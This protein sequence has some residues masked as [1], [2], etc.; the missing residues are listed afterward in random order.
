MYRT[1]KSGMRIFVSVIVAVLAAAL[2]GGAI[3]GIVKLVNY[4]NSETITPSL[5]W[6][7]GALDENGDYRADKGSLYTKNA[8]ECQ[9]LNTELCFDNNISYEV[10]FYDSTDEF[11]YSSGKQ[12]KNYA[13]TASDNDLRT[14]AVSRARIVITP[15]DDE[16]ITWFEKNGYAKQLEVTV[17][18]S[19][20][21]NQN[22]VRVDLEVAHWAKMDD[23]YIDFD[24]SE[25]F[26]LKNAEDVIPG[27]KT[28]S[29]VIEAKNISK[30]TIHV[31]NVN[32]RKVS[33]YFANLEHENYGMDSWSDV[34][35]I[36]KT[37]EVTKGYEDYLMVTVATEVVPSLEIYFM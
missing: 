25:G 1:K 21:A 30:V 22:I 34:G 7:V 26:Q 20:K 8:F 31:N 16:E 14:L 17:N 2:V 33:I 32:D 4:N 6:A 37:V 29:F 11:L 24:D 23:K 36:T 13:F 15:D 9:G 27:M 5:S 19:Q 3:F 10:F 28:T 35:E 12:V 18:K